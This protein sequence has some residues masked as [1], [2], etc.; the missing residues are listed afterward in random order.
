VLLVDEVLEEVGHCL[1]TFTVPKM[2]R[3]LFL[4]H[5]Q[6]LGRLCQAG[7]E[8]VRELIATAA[9][10]PCFQPGMVSVVQTAGDLL[11][12]ILMFTPW[13]RAAAGIATAAGYP[14]PS[15]TQ[16]QRS[17]SSATG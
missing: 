11:R 3:P 17:D 9:G 6:L 7:W 12:G 1:W 4:H 10:D 15:W 8:T 2:L 14:S 16:R 5:R 13:A